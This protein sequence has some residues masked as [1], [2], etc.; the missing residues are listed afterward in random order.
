MGRDLKAVKDIRVDLA[1]ATGAA[2][3]LKALSHPVRLC[4]V[5]GLMETGRCNVSEMQHCLRAPQSTISQHL[6][7]L[8]AS[9]I[10]EGERDGVEVY[11]RVVSEDA[12]RVVRALFEM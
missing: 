6:A 4:I 8:R 2:E 5:K 11:Y 10:I 7:R 3:V 9:R 12:K 1:R